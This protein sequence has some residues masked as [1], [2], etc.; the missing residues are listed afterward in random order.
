VEIEALR[1]AFGPATEDTLAEGA[2]LVIIEIP[3]AGLCRVCGAEVE[4]ETRFDACPACG[5]GFVDV[6][7]GTE[8]RIKDLDVE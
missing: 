6:T 1:F 8:L 3:G 2:E 5:E 4:V 7:G